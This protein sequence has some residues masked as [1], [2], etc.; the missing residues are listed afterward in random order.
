[1]AA[2]DRQT[3]RQRV[4]LAP[5]TVWGV[6]NA[7]PAFVA[8][9]L[10]SFDIGAAIEGQEEIKAMGLV[11]VQDVGV[12]DEWS[13]GSIGERLSFDEIGHVLAMQQGAPTTTTPASA[14]LTRQHVWKPSDGALWT[15]KSR[16]II[17]GIAGVSQTRDEYLGVIATDVGMEFTR[18][19]A[20]LSGAV[21]GKQHTPGTVNDPPN[22]IPAGAT[23]TNLTPRPMFGK[24][25]NVWIDPTPGAIGTTLMNRVKR[26]A[27]RANGYN[28]LLWALKDVDNPDDHLNG[29]PEHRVEIWMAKDAQ[30]SPLITQRRTGTILYI[31]IQNTG[32][33]IESVTPDYYEQLTIDI[34]AK[35]LEPDQGGD[36]DGLYGHTYTLVPVRDSTL[37][38]DL[39]YKI[40]LLNRITAY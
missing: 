16:S 29:E 37:T 27:F 24:D 30:G 4:Y 21:I 15:P 23:V 20:V 25:T 5:E 14:V 12:G 13:A 17:K 31:R 28:T 19:T 3:S 8:M 32:R 1:M 9:A 10:T 26:V 22:N 34:A 38:I 6:M 36:N 35:I 33:L 2:T 7:T 11:G 40:T 18:R 39:G